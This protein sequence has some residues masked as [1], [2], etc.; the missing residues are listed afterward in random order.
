VSDLGDSLAAFEPLAERLILTGVKDVTL[1]G[2]HL[3]W[4][5]TDDSLGR[6]TTIDSGTVSKRLND[7]FAAWYLM[8][9]FLIC[10]SGVSRWLEVISWMHPA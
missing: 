3:D 2:F 7:G 6:I 4:S 10:I 5:L 1:S 8:T 9:L